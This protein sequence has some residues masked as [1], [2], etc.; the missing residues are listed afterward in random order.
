MQ[1]DVSDIDEVQAL[2]DFTVERF[3]RLDIMFNNAGVGSAMKRFLPDDLEDFDRIMSVNLFGV[4]PIPMISCASPS[5]RAPRAD[6]V[7]TAWRPGRC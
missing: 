3:G 7:P 1:T 5:V 4:I 6:L 2:V